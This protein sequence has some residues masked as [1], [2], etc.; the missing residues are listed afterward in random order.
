MSVPPAPDLQG[1]LVDL[2]G[3]L[4]ADA[5]ALTPSASDPEVWQGKLVPRPS[6]VTEMRALIEAR[7]R[8][9][10]QMFT[11]RRRIGGAVIGST[12][13]ANFDFANGCVEMGFTWLERAAW[14][15]G[16]NEDM[17]CSLLKYCFEDLDFARV[18]CQVDSRNE[19]SR[20]ALARLGFTHEGTL[21]SRHVRPDG[22]RRDSLVFSL[23]DREW[24]DAQRHL[25]ALVADRSITRP[26]T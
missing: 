15:Q 12:S 9:G 6:T 18:E 24:P 20:R 21:R 17:K 4:T 11:V 8:P 1:V 2:S 22:T 23:L 7:C 25:L 19:R 16:Y 10:R 26:P 3:V 13:L 14:G 5:D